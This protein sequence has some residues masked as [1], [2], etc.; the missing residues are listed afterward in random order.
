MNAQHMCIEILASFLNVSSE[1]KSV[2]V[3]RIFAFNIEQEGLSCDLEEIQN[4][5][6][7][8]Y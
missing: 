8:L 1:V 4:D 5:I 3:S 7:I 6:H 2:K